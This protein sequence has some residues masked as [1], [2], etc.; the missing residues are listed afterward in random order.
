MDAKV[1][2]L[3]SLASARGRIFDFKVL[4][5]INTCQEVFVPYLHVDYDP[6]ISKK[7]RE[8]D[9]SSIKHSEVKFLMFIKTKGLIFVD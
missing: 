7:E 3:L 5:L 4:F 2:H 8:R 9:I 1:F 6:L